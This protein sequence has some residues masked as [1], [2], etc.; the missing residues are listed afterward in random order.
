[1]VISEKFTVGPEMKYKAR[2]DIEINVNNLEDVMLHGSTTLK[3]QSM[4]FFL[5]IEV[6]FGS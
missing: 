1:M 3:P 5:G 2:Q 4:Q 6:L